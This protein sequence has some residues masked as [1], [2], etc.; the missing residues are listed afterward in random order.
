M[1]QKYKVTLLC[2]KVPVDFAA[3]KLHY[4]LEETSLLQEVS[5]FVLNQK[6]PFEEF[7]KD[8]KGRPIIFWLLFIFFLS[9]STIDHLAS[10]PPVE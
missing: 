10:A 2:L 8:T 7:F 5:F 1:F 4:S 6:S 3:V 9:W